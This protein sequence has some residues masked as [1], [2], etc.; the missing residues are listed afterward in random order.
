MIYNPLVRERSRV[1]S[2][3]AA[4]P[5]PL[6]CLCF[7]G[8]ACEWWRHQMCRTVQEHAPPGGKF[9]ARWNPCF[10][11]VSWTTRG[12]NRPRRCI[13]TSRPSGAFYMWGYRTSRWSGTGF[14]SCGLRGSN[15]S[16]SEAS[17]GSQRL[18]LQDGQRL[19]SL[20]TSAPSS[21]SSG[22]GLA[23]SRASRTHGSLIWPAANLPGNTQRGTGG[24]I[25]LAHH[26]AGIF[27]N[28]TNRNGLKPDLATFPFRSRSV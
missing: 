9:L 24:P 13:A 28:A 15:M 18:R 11:Q 26:G 10:R 4:P 12:G 21:T 3:L 5:K 22:S 16:R 23:H 7:T 27:S 19:L 20:P 2:S 8:R 1:Q 14:T 6:K 17:N 25:S